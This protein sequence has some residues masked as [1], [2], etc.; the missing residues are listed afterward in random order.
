MSFDFFFRGLDPTQAAV[1]VVVPYVVFFERAMNEVPERTN[2]P[3]G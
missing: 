2:S 3:S 1:P